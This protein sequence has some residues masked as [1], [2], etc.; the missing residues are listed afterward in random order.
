MSEWRTHYPEFR[1]VGT[2]CSYMPAEMIHAAGFAPVRVRSR[3]IPDRQ[4]SF[5]LPPYTCALS[6]G[7]LNL[8]TAGELGCL[9]GMVFAHTCDTLQAMAD[10]CRLDP[11]YQGWVETVMLPANLDQPTSVRYLSTELLRFRDHLALIAGR[12]LCNEELGASISL[13]DEIRRLATALQSF[14]DRLSATD[15]Y[16]IMDAGQSMPPGLFHGLLSDLLTEVASLPSITRGPRVFLAGAML[17]EPRLIG[18]FDNLGADIAG[19]DLC[20][21]YRRFQGQ[22]GRSS[23]PLADLCRYYIQRLP[24]PCKRYAGKDTPQVLVERVQQARA[25]GV[26]FL[27]PKYCEPQAFEFALLR[28]GLEKA[29]LPYLVLDMEDQPPLEALSTRIQAFTEIL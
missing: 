19:D 17:D 24:C 5:R 3:D 15:Y 6:R 12:P 7:V 9:E 28:P 16:A 29:R 4:S 14:R 25:E 26:V 21:G 2:L 18:V 13:Y 22:V 27:L 1:A 11:T 23:E 8:L 10:L 20:T